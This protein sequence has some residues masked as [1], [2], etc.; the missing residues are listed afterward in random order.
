MIFVHME[1]KTTDHAGKNPDNQR[2]FTMDSSLPTGLIS[3]I[4]SSLHVIV[5]RW[6]SAMAP[7]S[8]EVVFGLFCGRLP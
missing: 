2:Y 5:N 6:L 1:L 7:I 4:A 8:T 3:I